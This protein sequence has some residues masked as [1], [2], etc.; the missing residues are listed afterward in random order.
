M[1]YFPMYL[2]IENRPCLVVGGH[3]TAYQKIKTLLDFGADIRVVSSHISE[4]V[5]DLLIANK[6]SFEERNVRE[7][8]VQGMIL[9][10]NAAADPEADRMIYQACVERGIAVNTVDNEKYSTFIFPAIYRDGDIIASVSSCGASPSAAAWVRDRIREMVPPYF[11]EIVKQQRSLRK[12]LKKEE[13][14]AAKRHRVMKS[15]FKLAVEK[16]RPLSEKEIS[17]LSSVD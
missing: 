9:V 17:D 10:V 14:D 7:E 4:E 8:D 13:P 6:M 2:N 11:G 15:S 16:G 1:T 12:K 3:H 5:M